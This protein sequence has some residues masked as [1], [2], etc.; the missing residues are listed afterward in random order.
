MRVVIVGA[1]RVGE[2]LIKKLQEAKAEITVI[3]EDAERAKKIASDYDVIIV[4]E[5]AV[6]GNAL[7]KVNLE[8]CDAF[9]SVSPKDEINLFAC[10]TAKQKGA[11][12]IISRISDHRNAH[13]F[14]HIG[15]DV[16]V[17]PQ[18]AAAEQ[19]MDSIVH[20]SSCTIKVFENKEVALREIKLNGEKS[21]VVG[22]KVV[23]LNNS[24]DFQIVALERTNDVI[25][26][27]TG[28]TVQP[29]DNL[30]IIVNQAKLKEIEE[31]FGVRSD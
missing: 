26:P 9:V 3:E 4:N 24:E 5:S 6:D 14:E 13:M 15:V 31:L 29:A 11:Q 20:P 10:L 8:K 22:E 2:N 21:D 30:L 28:T 16:V 19:I 1:G 7:D 12:R 25:I 23:D 18:I 27:H 17:M